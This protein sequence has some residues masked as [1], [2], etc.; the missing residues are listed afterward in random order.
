MLLLD[1]DPELLSSRPLRCAGALAPLRALPL[2]VCGLLLAV[3]GAEFGFEYV[4]GDSPINA[5][6]C[7]VTASSMIAS[8]IMESIV[9]SLSKV[10]FFDVVG[11]VSNCNSKGKEVV[12]SFVI[13]SSSGLDAGTSSACDPVL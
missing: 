3:S 8:L 2:C 6:T 1:A 4:R 13:C 5:S 10:I 11:F 7:P 9:R 12:G